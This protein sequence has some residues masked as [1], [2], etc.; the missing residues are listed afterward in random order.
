[1][2][3]IRRSLTAARSYDNQTRVNIAAC[4][5][6]FL[7]AA[8]NNVASDFSSA[9]GEMI[10]NSTRHFDWTAAHFGYEGKARFFHTVINRPRYVKIFTPNSTPSCGDSEWKQHQGDAEAVFYI[11]PY[12]KVDFIEDF[13]AVVAELGVHTEVDFV[14]T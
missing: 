7:H 1:A 5:L 4:G 8:E 2:F 14:V 13:R 10:V 6:K 3:S 12:M 9:E 11:E